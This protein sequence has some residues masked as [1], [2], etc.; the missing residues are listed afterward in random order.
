[1]N[2]PHPTQIGVDSS[3]LVADAKARLC[4]L[5]V[6]PR[7]LSINF[8]DFLCFPDFLKEMD[9]E[10]INNLF[11]FVWKT[12]KFSSNIPVDMYFNE[13]TSKVEQCELSAGIIKKDEKEIKLFLILAPHSHL[14]INFSKSQ[15]ES[16][17]LI[18]V[19]TDYADA[20][21]YVDDEFCQKYFLTEK[22][23]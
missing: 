23:Q 17:C 8:L 6:V 1:M 22:S 3:I 15:I 16:I 4:L 13:L 5:N 14:L 21:N 20:L 18:Q 12:C 19:M 9:E 2:T 7:D 10:K 11:D